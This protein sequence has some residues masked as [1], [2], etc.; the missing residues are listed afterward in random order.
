MRGGGREKEEKKDGSFLFSVSP[1]KRRKARFRNAV[2]SLG[3][4]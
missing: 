1:S 4:C 2:S 3:F